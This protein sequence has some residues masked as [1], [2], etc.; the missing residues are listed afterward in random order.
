[1]ITVESADAALVAA[2]PAIPGL[3]DV[4]DPT[5]LLER[6][7]WDVAV[8]EVRYV[9][10]KPATSIIAGIALTDG[11]GRVSMAQAFAFGH[12]GQHKVEKYLWAGEA[13]QVGRGVFVDATTGVGL[14]DATA[15][16]HL[17][18]IARLLADHPSVQPLVYKPGKRWV[19]RQDERALTKIFARD[20]VADLSSRYR[21]LEGLP[22]PRVLDVNARRGRVDFEWIPGTTVDRLASFQVPHYTRLAGAL[23]AQVHDRPVIP[24]LSTVD[25][26]SEL[27]AALQALEGI[28]PRHGARARRIADAVLEGLPAVTP[29]VVHGDFSADQVVVRDGALNGSG[30][31]A[32]LDLDRVGLDDPHADLGSWFGCGVAVGAIRD[33]TDI[34]P[35]LEGYRAAGGRLDL[36]RLQLH[37]ASGVLHRAVEPFRYRQPEWDRGIDRLID[38]AA[39]L[40]GEGRRG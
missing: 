36:R 31:L 12:G 19:G 15:D 6:S 33:L 26:G 11:S 24:G 9:R 10:Y 25:L 2:D 38:L 1:M 21:A 29:G 4:L 18:G 35:L 13:D 39:E 20:A 3:R 34:E 32:L 5:G 30:E 28:A 37:C 27:R 7:G 8:A 23:L 17:P 14:A 22:V 40:V 16:R